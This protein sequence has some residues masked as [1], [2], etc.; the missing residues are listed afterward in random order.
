MRPFTLTVILLVLSIGQLE[1]RSPIH[2]KKSIVNGL[3][4]NAN[5]AHFIVQVRQYTPQ[6]PTY[7]TATLCGGSLI[8]PQTVVTAAHCLKGRY[9]HPILNQF[10]QFS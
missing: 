8:A 4:V 2:L 1:A 7:Y 5:E 3:A 9:V 6:D 10:D